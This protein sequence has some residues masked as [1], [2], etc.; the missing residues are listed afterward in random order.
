MLSFSLSINT[1]YA[2]TLPKTTKAIKNLYIPIKYV[3]IYN[4]ACKTDIIVG[5]ALDIRSHALEYLM[6]K[7]SEK[8]ADI[9]TVEELKLIDKAIS[10]VLKYTKNFEMSVAIL[11]YNI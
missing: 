8:L 3:K 2:N 4:N 1:E 10:T 5:E 11:N 9:R 7:S 6:D